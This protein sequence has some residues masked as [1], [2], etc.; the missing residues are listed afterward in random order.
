MEKKTFKRLP[1]GLTN[2]EKLRL[3]NYA[4]VNKTKYILPEIGCS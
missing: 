4:F 2:F 3:E 1:Y